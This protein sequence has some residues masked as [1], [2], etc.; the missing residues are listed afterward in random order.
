MSS[1]GGPNPRSAPYEASYPR[2]HHITRRIASPYASIYNTAFF[3]RVNEA[4][5]YESERTQRRMASCFTSTS[6]YDRFMDPEYRADANTDEDEACDDSQQTH[7]PDYCLCNTRHEASD[8][9]RDLWE[10]SLYNSHNTKP[11]SGL[12]VKVRT[13]ECQV[14]PEPHIST[15]TGDHS[16]EKQNVFCPIYQRLAFSNSIRLLQILPSEPDIPIKCSL[17]ETRLN[18]KCVQ[19]EA[20][21]YTWGDPLETRIEITCDGMSMKIRP[22]LHHALKRL[23]SKEVPRLL[24]V[25]A[26]C[27][28]QSNDIER[29][30]QVNLMGQIYEKAE[31]VLVWLGEDVHKQATTAFYVLKGVVQNWKTRRQWDNETIYSPKGNKRTTRPATNIPSVDSHSWLCVSAL[32]DCS[33]F[34]RVWVIQEVVLA[35]KAILIWGGN[36]ILWRDIGLAAAIIRTNDHKIVRRHGMRGIY[37]AYLMYRLS[38]SQ[39]MMEPL[40]NLSF[41]DLLQ[42]TRQFDSTDPRDRVYS[43]LGLLT[44]DNSPRSGASFIEPDYTISVDEL[45]GKVVMKIIHISGNLNVLSGVQNQQYW[46]DG[47]NPFVSWVPRWDTAFSSTL[48]SWDVD[49]VS[50]AAGRWSLE[51][52]TT[53]VPGSLIVKAIIVSEVTDTLP[54]MDGEPDREALEHPSLKSGLEKVWGLTSLYETL[55]AG[56][57]WYGSRDTEPHKYQNDLIAYIFSDS[58]H[59]SQNFNAYSELA[60]DGD[61]TRF[62]ET[63]KNA[64]TQRRLFHIF[65]GLLG[66]GPSCAEPGDV[67]CVLSGCRMPFVLRKK[68]GYFRLLGECYVGGIMN[69]EGVAAAQLAFP[70]RYGCPSPL[71]KEWIELR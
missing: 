5:A 12:P 63:S 23:R 13:P 10:L 3:G 64:C 8:D 37:N 35:N 2:P 29:G 38:Q 20:L 21:S 60:K 45:Y 22:N 7:V 39:D 52:Y 27:I 11:L 46:I 41:L 71:K 53:E 42:L 57:H 58:I 65:G 61:S 62:M 9:S 33:W 30:E 1:D 31:T 18:E 67:V 16:S 19:Y 55:T 15:K 50:S 51:Y 70:L 32:F 40:V 6:N 59:K 14:N 4:E 47:D 49:D 66:L 43:I 28:D 34:W 69:G 56:K 17:I 36:E 44:V 48:A 25:D 68:E 26:V 54:V 24:W